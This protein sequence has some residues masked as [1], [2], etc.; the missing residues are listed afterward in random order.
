MTYR[1]LLP[2]LT[3]PHAHVTGLK[4]VVSEDYSMCGNKKGIEKLAY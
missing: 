4:T 2:L 3:N 1:P